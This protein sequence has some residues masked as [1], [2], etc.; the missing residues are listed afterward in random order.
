MLWIAFIYR[1]FALWKQRRRAEHHQP[2]GCELLSFIVLLLF[3]NSDCNEA[4]HLAQV[5][6]CFHLSYFCSLKTAQ[7][8]WR[9]NTE[10]L[11]IAFIY[12]TFAL[13]KQLLF[14]KNQTKDRCELLSFIV[15]LLFENS[16]LSACCSAACVVNCFHLSYFCSL[17]T[18]ITSSI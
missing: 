11:W 10:T 8:R 1:T 16:S 15:L 9:I 14:P 3:E 12:R 2:E 7:T 4:M 13:W 5:V 18:A 6:N 17:K